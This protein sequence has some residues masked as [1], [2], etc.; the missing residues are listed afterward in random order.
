MRVCESVP[1]PEAIKVLPRQGNIPV[2][3]FVYWQA[4]RAHF[5]VL[6]QNF[7]MD[8]IEHR[9]CGICGKALKSRIAFV[10]GAVSERTGQY[11]A[12]ASHPEC[13]EYAM[14]VCPSMASPGYK[15]STEPNAQVQAQA[16]HPGA[17]LRAMVMCRGYRFDS[18]KGCLEPRGR[19]EPVWYLHGRL[20]T[21]EEIE[22]GRDYANKAMAGSG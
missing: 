1:M 20:A 14:K 10:G 4:G 8:A 6:D 3:K 5:K 12:P 21:S 9:L 22:M 16:S 13:A 2:P 18:K 19:F 17:A 15:A 11:V 7:V